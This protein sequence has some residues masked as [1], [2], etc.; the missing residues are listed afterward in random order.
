MSSVAEFFQRATKA[1]IIPTAAYT[2]WQQAVD[3]VQSAP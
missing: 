1:A 3:Q 2:L